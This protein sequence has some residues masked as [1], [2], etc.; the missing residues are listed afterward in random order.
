MSI[1]LASRA[2]T[3]LL[4]TSATI[5]LGTVLTKVIHQ[6]LTFFKEHN[7][8]T[9]NQRLDNKP[10]NSTNLQ[11]NEHKTYLVMTQNILKS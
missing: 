9:S 1:N 8:S 5:G 4:Q 3:S 2:A 10:A 7:H 6:G 11:E